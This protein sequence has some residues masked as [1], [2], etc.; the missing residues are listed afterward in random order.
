MT[1]SSY[2][3]LLTTLDEAHW[4]WKSSLLTEADVVGVFGMIETA[5]RQS[6]LKERGSK[7]KHASY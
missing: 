2:S 1:L 3:Q 6:L 7:G 4:D 5:L